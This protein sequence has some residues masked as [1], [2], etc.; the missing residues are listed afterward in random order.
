MKSCVDLAL[1]A[2]SVDSQWK[3]K[4]TNPLGLARLV[5][6]YENLVLAKGK[7]ARSN[8]E[9]LLDERQQECKSPTSTR[10]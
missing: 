7:T 8:W 10:E 1:L 4:Y 3:G 2:R 5:A 9:A 6:V